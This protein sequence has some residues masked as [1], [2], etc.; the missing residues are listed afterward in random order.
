M[1]WITPKTDWSKSDKFTYTDYNR[2]RNNLLYLNNMLNEKYPNVAKDLDLGDEATYIT[3]YVPS[4]FNAFEDALESFKRISSD[5]NIGQ[6]KVFYDNSPFIDYNELNRLENCCLRWYNFDPVIESVS[7]TPNSFTLNEG[8]T[9]T[10]T[11]S[12]VP[13]NAQHTVLWSS[14]NTAVATVNNGVVTALAS[15]TV[16]ITATAQQQGKPDKSATSNGTVEA[17]ATA[18]TLLPSEMTLTYLEQ[19]NLSLTAVPSDASNR[20]DYDL[21][22]SDESVIKVF[23]NKTLDTS[24]VKA[25]NKNGVATITATLGSLTSSIRVQAMMLMYYFTAGS[26]VIGGKLHIIGGS[27]FSNTDENK[28]RHHTRIY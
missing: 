15:G 12:V 5:A 7:L 8:D 22:S 18:I 2:I 25:R 1:A 23:R 20:K 13:S 10:L 24:I 6:K 3:N 9:I 4:Q 28:C 27:S 19:G 17:S 16:I 26:A 14:S 21:V 11:F